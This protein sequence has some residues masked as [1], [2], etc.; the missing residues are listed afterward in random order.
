LTIAR[1]LLDQASF[2]FGLVVGVAGSLKDITVSLGHLL[3]TF[4]LA[5]LY[6]AAHSGTAWAFS[7]IG[8]MHLEAK[9]IELVA[10]EAMRKAHQER[11]DL[12]RE[13]YKALTNLRQTLVSLAGNVAK[14]YQAKWDMLLK[15]RSQKDLKARYEEG[16]ITGEVLVDVILLILT[17]MDGVGAV[18]ALA[19][20][21]GLIRAA[22]SLSRLG[23]TGT[24]EELKAASSAGGIRSTVSSNSRT[25]SLPAREVLDDPPKVPKSEASLARSISRADAES[26]LIDNGLSPARAKDFI[27]SF[28]GPITIRQV[29]PGE[30]FFRYTDRAESTGN[31]LTKQAFASPAEAVEKLFLGPYKNQASLVQQVTSVKSTSVFEGAV[32]NGVPPGTIQSLMVDGSAFTFGTGVSFP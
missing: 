19:E 4:V 7:P 8:I 25:K 24:A 32:A 18:K 26:L 17:V 1:P 15:L 27:S 23:R 5:A 12:L 30:T 9:A 13:L 21:P 11:N 2:E 20:L 14:S 29:N 22:R 28:D 3:R 10:G 6:D 31:F 16:K